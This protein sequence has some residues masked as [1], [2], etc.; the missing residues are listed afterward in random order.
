MEYGIT[1]AMPLYSGGLGVLAGDHL[2]TASDLGIPLTAVGLF[3]REGYFRQMLD[4]TGA[5]LEVYAINS[6]DSMPVRQVVDSAGTPLRVNI[7]LP[8]RDLRM[9]IWRATVG[10][11]DL[12]CSTATTRSIRPSTAASP[13][14][15][16]AAT[17]R[18][19][20]EESGRHR[21]WRALRRS[22]STSTSCT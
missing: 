17:A 22:A 19:D 20:H 9:R 11:V 1:D 15:S 4:T 2:K 18:R 5:Q 7:E 6:R 16:T 12:T 21:G 14:T 13:A 8:G 10:R 3:Y